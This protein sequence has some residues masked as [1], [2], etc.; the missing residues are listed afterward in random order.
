M[1]SKP[2]LCVDWDGVIHS[3][4]SGWKGA[5]VIPDPPV[6]GAMEWLSKAVRHFQVVIYSS[7]SK[8]PEAIAAMRM[9]LSY[10]SSSESQ[11]LDLDAVAFAHEKPSAFLTIDDRALCFEGDW[12]KLDPE[13]LLAFKP[14][15]QRDQLRQR[16]KV[17][18]TE[19]LQEGINAA[20]TVSSIDHANR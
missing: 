19:T 9:W 10:H 14:W 18:H 4:A 6:P 12:G 11:A 3:C 17:L 2:I 15:R 8:D 16:E 13:K 1:S 7:R 20:T 5:A